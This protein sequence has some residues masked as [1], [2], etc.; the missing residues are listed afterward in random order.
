M[1]SAVLPAGDKPAVSALPR[2]YHHVLVAAG[3]GV[4]VLFV[5]NL[6]NLALGRPWWTVTQ[7]IDLGMESNLPTWFSSLLWAVAAGF[8]WVCGRCGG[9]RRDRNTF[10][11]LAVLLALFSMDEVAMVHERVG[12]VLARR[13]LPDLVAVFPHTSWPL[14]LGP[15]VLA[16]LVA[17]ALYAWP[18]LCRTP[19][20]A[21]LLIGGL[22]CAVAGGM[23]L[24]FAINFL[25]HM[26]LEWLWQLEVV[27]EET[28]ELTGVW[29][30]LWAMMACHAER[31]AE[32]GG[33]L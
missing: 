23:V 24:E 30:T 33:S 15:P 1:G 18:V 13:L 20:A 7:L 21:G 6:F 14:V 26:D 5:A 22:T 9:A 19:R 16:V 4:V 27:A 2:T 28:L 10:R 32:I 8:A 25:N 17:V 31:P 29:L 12:G 3:A 11:V